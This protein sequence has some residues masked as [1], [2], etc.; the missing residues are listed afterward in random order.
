MLQFII[1]RLIQVVPVLIGVSFIVFAALYLVP[2][3]IANTML[4]MF[5]TEERAV[6][7]RA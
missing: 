3:D 4:G 6:A 2:G 5:Y 1:W 7:L